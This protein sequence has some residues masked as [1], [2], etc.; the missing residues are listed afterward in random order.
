MVLSSSDFINLLS[1]SNTS[2]DNRMVS[3]FWA[4][5]LTKPDKVVVLITAVDR[6]VASRGS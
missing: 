1:I 4:K 2:G 6:S 5:C 3:L